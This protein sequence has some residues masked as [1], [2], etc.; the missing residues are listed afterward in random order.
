MLFCSLCILFGFPLP[1]LL[2]ESSTEYNDGELN[3]AWFIYIEKMQAA[4]GK[5]KFKF[6]SK[7]DRIHQSTVF[8]IW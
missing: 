8:S 6:F 4:L 5:R 2:S 1:Y 7:E 3:L